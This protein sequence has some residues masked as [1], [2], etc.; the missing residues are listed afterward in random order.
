M[1]E[2]PLHDSEAGIDMNIEVSLLSDIGHFRQ[3]DVARSP[4]SNERATRRFAGALDTAVIAD[5]GG[6]PG[7]PPVGVMRE[8]AA[9]GERVDRLRE[10]NRELRF[11]LNDD[12]GRVQIEIRDLVGNLIREIPPSEALE[13]ASGALVPTGSQVPRRLS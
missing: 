10:T 5:V 4:A 12:T 13:V 2:P 11:N 8:V 7:S 1:D 9:A 3:P 6:L